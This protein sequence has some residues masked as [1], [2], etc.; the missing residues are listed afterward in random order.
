MT[1]DRQWNAWSLDCTVTV[2]MTSTSGFAPSHAVILSPSWS[3]S[4]GLVPLNT[5]HPV[6]PLIGIVSPYSGSGPCSRTDDQ[7]QAR[8]HKIPRPVLLSTTPPSPSLKSPQPMHTPR[9]GTKTGPAKRRSRI[10]ISPGLKLSE[11]VAGSACFF[12]AVFMSQH[13]P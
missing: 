9:S 11:G 4:L 8:Q 6:Y 13:L 1:S 2:A 7:R 10:V 12:V 3:R 5:L